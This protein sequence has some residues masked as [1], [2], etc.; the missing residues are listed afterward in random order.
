MNGVVAVFQTI[1][2]RYLFTT[3]KV[4]FGS[5]I[6]IAL[7]DLV[8]SGSP[9]KQIGQAEVQTRKKDNERQY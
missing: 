9:N 3:T 4:G 1:V 8:I 5:I 2:V 6:K 7:T